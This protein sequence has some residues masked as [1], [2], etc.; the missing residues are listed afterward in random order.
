[1]KAKRAL[2]PLEEGAR[3][4]LIAV[5]ILFAVLNLDEVEV[6]LIFGSPEI[7]L[8]FVIVACLIVGAI[9]DRLLVRQ[10]RRRSS[11]PAGQDLPPPSAG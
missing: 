1:M 6:H 5:A 2:V 11:Q 3:S 8:I 10:T 9:I 7:P 4:V